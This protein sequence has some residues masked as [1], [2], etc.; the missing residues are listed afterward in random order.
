[1]KFFNNN[2]SNKTD[3]SSNALLEAIEKN[4]YKL[5]NSL[6]F[7]DNEKATDININEKDSDGNDPFLLAVKNNNF[8]IAHSIIN[9]AKKNNI[10][11]NI[12]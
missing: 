11:L 8:D 10:L 5:F 9:Y 12:E 1:M 7:K 4:D 3:N 6:L 2:T